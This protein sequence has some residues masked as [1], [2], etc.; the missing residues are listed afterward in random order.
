MTQAFEIASERS[1][2]DRSAV[3]YRRTRKVGIRVALGASRA[4]VVALMLRST[5]IGAT[6][7][8]LAG[9]AVSLATS[10][11]LVNYL[12]EV[13]PRDPATYAVIL[14]FLTTIAMLASLLPARRAA[15]LQPATVLRGE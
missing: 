1:D 15:A 12:F 13:E 9:I 4:R 11:V 10:R 6:A 8:V 5:L 7:G 2:G 14:V 3:V